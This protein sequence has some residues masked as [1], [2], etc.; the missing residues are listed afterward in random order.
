MCFQDEGEQAVQALE[1]A[2]IGVV[3]T[4]LGLSMGIAEDEGVT[5]RHILIAAFG[6]PLLAPVLAWRAWLAR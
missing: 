6:W 1:I 4:L 3:V 5:L 2:Y